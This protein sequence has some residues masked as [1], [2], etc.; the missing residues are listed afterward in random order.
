MGLKQ[1][2]EAFEQQKEE[3]NRQKEGLQRNE[4]IIREADINIQEHLIKYGQSLVETENKTAKTRSRLHDD[5]LDVVDIEEKI[6][7][8]E[9]TIR[10]LQD[11]SKILELKILSLK[12]YDSFLGQITDKKNSFSGVNEM[13]KRHEILNSSCENQDLHRKKLEKDN[14]LKKE[15]IARLEYENSEKVMGLNN[16]IARLQHE[17]DVLEKKK[18]NFHEE[19]DISMGKAHN[20]R[21]EFARLLMAIDNLYDRCMNC[22]IK[23]GGEQED[24]EESN[25]KNS[26]EKNDSYRYKCHVAVRKLRTIKNFEDGFERMFLE[27]NDK[28]E[29]KDKEKANAKNLNTKA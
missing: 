3:Y 16:E 22:G 7:S 26:Y 13:L 18:D 19:I 12:T 23:L 6:K 8:E 25:K 28:R 10:T 27:L 2:N 29:E 5:E 1:V 21:L 14:D 17:Y 11:H 9:A 20:Q 24:G 15:E 4:E